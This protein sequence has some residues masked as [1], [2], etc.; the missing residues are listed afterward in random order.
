MICKEMYGC[1]RKSLIPIAAGERVYSIYGFE[2]LFSKDAVD[3]AQPDM[4]HTGGMMECK[5]IAGMAE[6]F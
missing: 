3:I 6:A 1:K 4:F 5:K 2:D